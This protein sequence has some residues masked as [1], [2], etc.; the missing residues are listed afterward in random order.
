MDKKTLA[1][2]AAASAKNAKLVLDERVQARTTLL[3][4]ARI[5]EAIGICTYANPQVRRDASIPG[6]LK[7]I[8]SPKR[9]MGMNITITSIKKGFS[10]VDHNQ[11]V[12]KRV[13][14]RTVFHTVDPGKLVD[15][16]LKTVISMMVKGL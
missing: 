12:G 10:V 3:E 15:A 1:A 14:S 11:N 5:S 16:I 4:V 9:D 7:V 6:N 13:I 2:A 8:L